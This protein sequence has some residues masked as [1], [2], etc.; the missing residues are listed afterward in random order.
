L[1]LSFESG[2]PLLKG[3]RGIVQVWPSND[4]SKE[5]QGATSQRVKKVWKQ[6]QT[7]IAI[8]LM[9]L[10]LTTISGE[11]AQA[12]T[13]KRRGGSPLVN[14]A[15]YRFTTPDGAVQGGETNTLA[16]Q[17][18][19]PLGRIT[20][21]AGEQLTDYTG[22]SVGIYE[23]DASGVGLGPLTDLT[24]T[25][26]P[27]VPNNSI[28]SGLD[29]NGVNSNPFNLAADSDG[30]YN[31]LLDVNKG[32]LDVGRRYI[33]VIRPPSGG[34]YSPRRVRFEITG[35][36]GSTVSYLATSLDGRPL[37]TT[38]G[39]SSSS[40]ELT[41]QDAAQTGLSLAVID[42]DTSVCQAQSIQI[43]KGGDRAAAVVGDTAIYRLSVKNLATAPLDDLSV[44]DTPPV[45]FHLIP[46]SA[47]AEVK[48]IKV[49]LV[50]ESADDKTVRFKFNGLNLPAATTDSSAILNIAYAVTLTPDAVRGTGENIAS[51]FARRQDNNERVSD[52]PA[53][54][55]MRIN[56][57]ILSDCGTIIGR[58]FVDRNYDGEAQPDEVGVPNAVVFLED[59]NRIVT[60]EMGRFSV[61]NVLPGYHTGVLDLTTV[62]KYTIAPSVHQ[63][64]RQSPSRLV[65]L[66]PGGLVKMNFAVAPKAQEAGK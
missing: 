14:K 19:D 64:E 32:Q 60:D 10:T 37:S 51:A 23:A 55:R 5:V 33:M 34:A 4:R 7:K 24:T 48:G 41:I 45:G 52:G 57:G 62:P 16:P 46:E 40:G 50:V 58:V 25:E 3:V 38:S 36:N 6:Y 35:R 20:G 22:F 59:G 13:T 39:A 56:G 26:T 1:N 18:I 61:A 21:C 65:R 2:S 43:I 31:F 54:H 9:S 47:R 8:A 29:P 27:D 66:A 11:I 12:Q 63:V 53:R 15:S 30:T 42:L 49:P 28:P 17:L 44:T